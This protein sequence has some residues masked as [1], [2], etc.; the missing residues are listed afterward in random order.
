MLFRAHRH[1]KL[2]AFITV[3]GEKALADARAMEAEQAQGKWRG[4]LHGIPIALKDNID[5][6]G[7]RTTAASEIFKDRVPT[8]D[9]EVD[10]PVL[11]PLWVVRL[12]YSVLWSR[13]HQP[14]WAHCHT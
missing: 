10:A 2:D 8:E 9:A 12:L 5:T 11:Q 13:L 7:V 14:L 1:G 3:A 6:A 4:P